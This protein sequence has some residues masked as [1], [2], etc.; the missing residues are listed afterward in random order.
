V[1]P[2]HPLHLVVDSPLYVVTGARSLGPELVNV[3]L[4]SPLGLVEFPSEIRRLVS[5]AAG[6]CIQ[7]GRLFDELVSF[8]L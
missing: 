1:R 6:I 7:F 4:V 2:S 8:L 5:V 3:A